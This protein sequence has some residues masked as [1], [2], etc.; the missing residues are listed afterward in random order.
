MWSVYS[1]IQ[2]NVYLSSRRSTNPAIIVKW[3]VTGDI[4][5]ALDRTKA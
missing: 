4:K 2:Y 3:G 1:I 5:Y